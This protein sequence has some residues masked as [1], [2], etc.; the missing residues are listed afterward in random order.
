MRCVTEA[1]A[2]GRFQKVEQAES[3]IVLQKQPRSCAD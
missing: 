3:L 2:S 1:L